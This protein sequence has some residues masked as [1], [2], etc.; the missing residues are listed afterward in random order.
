MA[1]CPVESSCGCIDLPA[2]VSACVSVSICVSAVRDCDINARLYGLATDPRAQPLTVISY[3][4]E[5]SA[6][7]NDGAIIK[8]IQTPRVRKIILIKNTTI[9]DLQKKIMEESGWERF[10]ETY[11]KAVEWLQIS[12][13]K[14]AKPPKTFGDPSFADCILHNPTFSPI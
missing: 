10:R 5:T 12:Y 7:D 11:D 13:S 8:K 1:M 14:G 9:L 6:C 2:S 3:R 4:P